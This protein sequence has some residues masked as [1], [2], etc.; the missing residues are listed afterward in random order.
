MVTLEFL[1]FLPIP[2]KF[3]NYWCVLPY[4]IYVVLGMALSMLGRHSTDRA[5]PPPQRHLFFL[6]FGTRVH[7]LIGLGNSRAIGTDLG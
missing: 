3:W 4:P 5:N 7:I 2:P 6:S 1:I